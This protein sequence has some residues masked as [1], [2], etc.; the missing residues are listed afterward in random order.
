M[1][2]LDDYQHWLVSS[3]LRVPASRLAALAV[4]L[5]VREN[6]KDKVAD[7]ARKLATYELVLR[8]RRE[9]G[10]LDFERDPA[11]FEAQTESASA[12]WPWIFAELGNYFEDGSHYITEKRI[13]ANHGSMGF[14]FRHVV[15]A[16]AIHEESR[17]W[18][19]AGHELRDV[20]DGRTEVTPCEPVVSTGAFPDI[21]RS[22]WATSD[23]AWVQARQAQWPLIE[24][25]L[26]DTFRKKPAFVKIAQ[27]YFLAG[28]MPDWS[29]HVPDGQSHLDLFTLLWLHPSHDPAVLGALREQY[30][31]SPLTSATDI[32]Q[33]YAHLALMHRFAPIGTREQLAQRQAVVSLLKSGELMFSTLH[34]APEPREE[35]RARQGTWT[36]W[37]HWQK[38]RADLDDIHHF[39]QWLAAP[40][41]TVPARPFLFEPAVWR[42][43][44]AG[45]DDD[46]SLTRLARSQT[47]WG[48][49]AS[50]MTLSTW[51][52]P[53][54]DPLRLDAVARLRT[55]L[56]TQPHDADLRAAWRLMNSG[57][58]VYRE[59]GRGSRATPFLLRGASFDR[60]RDIGAL[61]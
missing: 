59:P 33:G 43:W 34:G 42:W 39:V 44:Q 49:L 3:H 48:V 27:R 55:W 29:R 30:V 12:R 24:P 5:H 46:S 40:P 36:G 11:T 53:D 32:T 6:A 19:W 15:R 22:A 17:H 20:E 18:T 16:G 38:W 8:D 1:T 21:D 56:D 58:F 25:V 35:R 10:G 14:Q 7:I 50:M 31:D 45:F 52:A 23:A 37:V 57:D 47:W 41:A 54:A 9:D 51:D 26:S 4:K 60:D 13:R 61:R 28:E 2:A